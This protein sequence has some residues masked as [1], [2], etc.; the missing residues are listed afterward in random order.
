MNMKIN[1]KLDIEGLQTPSPISETPEF[2][3]DKLNFDYS[4][5]VEYSG[6]ELVNVIKALVAGLTDFT[7]GV[8]PPPKAEEHNPFR[9][10]CPKCQMVRAEN[11]YPME[12]GLEDPVEHPSFHE[13]RANSGYDP[14]YDPL[15]KNE[16]EKDLFTRIA[17]SMSQRRKEQGNDTH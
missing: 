9:C 12:P 10:M 4:G 8:N 6:E 3:L 15:K 7:N 13:D 2:K 16:E 1:L 5:E 11:Y 14:N 17:E